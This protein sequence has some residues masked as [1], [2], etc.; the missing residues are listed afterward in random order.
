GADVAHQLEEGAATLRRRHALAQKRGDRHG[1]GAVVEQVFPDGSRCP[2]GEVLELV[3]FAFPP[4]RGGTA[5]CRYIVI[6]QSTQG[7]STLWVPGRIRVSRP[8][9]YRP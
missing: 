6:E 8:Y 4:L 7:R 3:F 1:I 5:G 2:G 9:S